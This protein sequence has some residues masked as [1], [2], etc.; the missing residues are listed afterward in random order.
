MRFDMACWVPALRR[1]VKDA[2]PRPGHGAEACLLDL[3]LAC[4]GRRAAPSA[5]S[6]A[7]STR[8]AFAAWRRGSAISGA[9]P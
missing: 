1:S 6:R 8:Y 3:P 9:P 7:S 5:G 2:A 4:P